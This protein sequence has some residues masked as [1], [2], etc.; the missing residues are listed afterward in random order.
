MAAPVR[1]AITSRRVLAHVLLIGAMTAATARA[2]TTQLECPA[3][4][5][6]LQ[7][8]V[9]YINEPCELEGDIVLGGTA[10]LVLL[11][12][13]LVVDGD[14]LL[15]GNS[16]LIVNNAHLVLDNHFVFDHKIESRGS[17]QIHFIDSSLK[18]N[19]SSPGH[20]LA[21]QYLAQ[22]QSILFVQNSQVLMPDSWLLG[23]LRGR[24][25]VHAVQSNFPSEIYPHEDATVIL[26]G[27]ATTSRVWLE[28]LNGSESLVEHLP[29]ELAPFD[30]SFGRRTPGMTNVGYQI[31]I[32]QARPT[33]GV[34]SHPGSRLTLRD[35]Q[36]P[37]AIGYFLT[38][39]NSPQHIVGLGPLSRDIVLDHQTRLF[40][41]DNA[42]SFEF[43]WQIYTANPTVL[44]PEP[45]V[46]RQSMINEIAA[47]ER[48]RVAVDACL[49]QW[50]VVAAIGPGSKIE[51]AGSTINS[52]S[53]I[54]ATDAV[55]HIDSSEIF[56]SLVEA[57]DDAFIL[58]SNVRFSPNICHALCLPACASL[59]NGG[60]EGNR[61]NPFTPAGGESVFK[62]ANR[63]TIAALGLQPI[64][65]PVTVG[66]TLNLRGDLFVFSGPGAQHTY[67]YKLRY[68]RMGAS[69]TG[70]IV[71][72][73]QG[74]KRGASLGVLNTSDLAAGAYVAI[75]ELHRDGEH[76]ATTSREFTLVSP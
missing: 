7:S 75:L 26:E 3:A 18:T 16:R 10:T 60:F 2:D 40:E 54:A 58:F 55:I 71:A 36:A 51:I 47:L 42:N 69:G 38:D 12:T 56:G 24:A 11:N 66:D 50:A 22:E 19:V 25:A 35:T 21:S 53:I 62:A 27:A 44:Q 31:E 34:A 41:L 4:S 45:V 76:L 13:T 59:E 64:D 6:N 70:T 15:S 39:L 33:V 61:C 46:V 43:A 49:L 65:T 73:G 5:I 52:Q 74:P 32:I 17:A 67:S 9:H 68:R 72:N 29:N 57:T 20:S 23:D 8:D 1:F 14:I 37:V 28:F 63:A 30:W 48:G